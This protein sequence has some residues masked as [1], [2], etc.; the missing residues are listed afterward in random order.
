MVQW[1]RRRFL[2]GFFV[3]VPL[4]VS[5][6]ALIWIFRLIDGLAGPWYAEWFGREV[7]GV[8]IVATALLVLL[9][10][11]L[12][13]QRHRQTRTATGGKLP[14]ACAGVPDDLCTGEAACSSLL[15]R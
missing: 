7:P 13:D 5:V 4:V 2:A 1:L 9:V 12:R 15:T 8:G 10:G 11:A 14:A 6:A 3:I